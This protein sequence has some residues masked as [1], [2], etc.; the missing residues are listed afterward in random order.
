MKQ[1]LA[2][3]VMTEKVVT[4]TPEDTV[5]EAAKVLV[6]NHISGAPVVDSDGKLVGLIS[7]S[8]LIIQDVKLRFPTYIH[9]LDSFI[10]LGNQ[11]HFEDTLRRAAAAKV[12]ELMRKEVVTAGPDT[13]LEEI[14]TLMADRHVGRIPIIDNDKVAGIITKGDIVRTLSR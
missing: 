10:F 6:D 2:K 13:D 14:A 5:K 11:R 8:D 7:E 9:F 12:G 4:L 1:T 3:D